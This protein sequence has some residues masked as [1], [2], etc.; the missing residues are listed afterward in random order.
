MAKSVG[1]I[2][3]TGSVTID[4]AGHAASM[5]FALPI[6]THIECTKGNA[7]ITIDTE[8]LHASVAKLTEW[9]NAFPNLP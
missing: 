7:R 3:I 4:V 9:I 8:S 5:D 1:S 6:D 2:S